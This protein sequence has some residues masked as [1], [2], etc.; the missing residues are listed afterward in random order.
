[1]QGVPDQSTEVALPPAADV[2]VVGAG[3]AGSA[4]ASHLA[5]GGCQVVLIDKARFPR[6]KCCGDGL[7]TGALRRLAELGLRPERLASWQR[8]DTAAIRTPSGRVF[9]FPLP[10]SGTFA[11]VVRRYELDTSLVTL[12]GQQ[13]ALVAEGHAF[14]SLDHRGGPRPLEVSV[15]SPSGRP[16]TIRC[17][18]VVGA[19]GMWSPL[20]KAVGLPEPGY[21]GDWHAFRQYFRTQGPDARLMWVFFDGD[22][23]PGYAWSF[24]LADGRVNVGFG[25]QRGAA[26][27]GGE[28]RRQWDAILARPHL[29]QVLGESPQPEGTLKTWPI[30]TARHRSPP[31]ALDGRVLFVGDA[32]RAPD[33]MTGE[34]IGQALETAELAA[35]AIVG[36][37]PHRSGTAAVSYQ[38]ALGRGLLVDDRLSVLL[39]RA[40]S[41]TRALEG[42]MRLVTATDRGS[43]TFARWMFEDYPRAVLVTPRR[44][45]P[46]L[47]HRPG[48]FAGTP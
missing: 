25:V 22:L 10:P 3:P 20:R 4:A 26:G 43:R 28:L 44:W 12:A 38:R 36:S 35:R 29:A 6:D 48:A 33:S 18:Y 15:A 30:P 40:L 46:G 42:A 14:R 5:I 37:G 47:L 13:G 21:L 17:S 31:S 2:V 16:L 9:D 1:M 32:A 8:V 7:T 24:P 23:L 39:S 41:R 45:R 27:S 34:G 19:D 11:A